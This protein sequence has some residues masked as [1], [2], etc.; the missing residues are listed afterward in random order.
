M[1]RKKLLRGI[2]GLIFLF[3]LLGAVSCVRLAI[4]NFMPPQPPS[5]A[6]TI[7]SDGSVEPPSSGLTRVGFGDTYIFS[8]DISGYTIVVEKDNVVI[9]GQGRT[10]QGGANSSA[11][12]WLQ[13]RH[14]VT[15]K[16]LVIKRFNVGVRQIWFYYGERMLGSNTISGNTFT[17]NTNAILIDDS[18]SGNVIANNTV[19]GNS[20]GIAIGGSSSGNVLRNNR[21]SNNTV[22][23][24]IQGSVNDVDAS[25]TVDGKPVYFLTD[26]HGGT[27][28][29]DAGYIAL[30][31]C[32]DITVENFN[33]SGNGQGILLI[34]DVNVTI[35][36]NRLTSNQNGIW[37]VGSSQITITENDIANNFYDG[38]YLGQTRDSRITSNTVAYNG[39]EGSDFGHV[40]GNSGSSGIRIY[41]SNVNITE[42]TVSNNGEGIDIQ[43]SNQTGIRRNSITN[44]KST[45][46]NLFGS[47]GISIAENTITENGENGIRI[48]ASDGNT[49]VSN[50]VTNNGLGILLDESSLNR[51]AENLVANNTGWGIQLK[52]ASDRFMSAANNTIIHNSFINNQQ[53]D[54]LDVSI[55]G[56]WTWPGGWVPGVGNT[57]DDGKEG[58]YWSDYKARYP[59]AEEVPGAGI[60]DTPWAINENNVDRCPLTGEYNASAY[61]PPTPTPSAP[62][63]AQP[64]ATP[65]PD[66]TTPTVQV[67]SPENAT[68][69]GNSVSL[70]FTVDQPGTWMGYS[71]NGQA[72]ATVTGNTTIVRLQ[73]GSHSVTVYA[74]NSAGTIGASATVNF[75]VQ[76]TEN[77]RSEPFSAAVVAAAGSSAVFVAVALVV[78]FH[79]RKR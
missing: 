41:S 79:R 23:L 63:T 46:I 28:P 42:N 6:I 9:D 78:L 64:T 62:S 49:A 67:N 77:Q 26:Q 43:S 47:S 55:P 30:V 25:N 38:I 50:R 2:L 74:R 51:I 57:W 53:G 48:W 73:D 11:G 36:H 34:N 8:D 32:S 14:H 60:W 18:S 33:L 58:N 66:V 22:N 61:L 40:L 72:N 37:V 12:V 10:L 1:V 3:A 35:R 44:Q 31:G 20:R 70:F 19:T 21:L 75:T 76:G 68:Y 29:P 15:I 59:E 5:P 24:D 45:G 4:A 56:I 52:S 54:G 16:D 17:D 27:V 13:S 71:L 65:K 7:R 39:A 69:T